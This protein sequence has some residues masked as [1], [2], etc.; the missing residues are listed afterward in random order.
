MQGLR[1]KAS[2]EDLSVVFEFG[3]WMQ[4]RYPLSL[5]ML[6]GVLSCRWDGLQATKDA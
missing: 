2:G 6:A 1:T 3:V 4:Q 5:Y